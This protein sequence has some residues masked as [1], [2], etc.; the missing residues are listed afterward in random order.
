M[1]RYRPSHWPC[2]LLIA[3]GWVSL[4]GCISTTPVP[5]PTPQ[6]SPSLDV[7]VLYPTAAATL[8]M[9]QTL[10][11]IIQVAE[12][13]GTPVG[14]AR[15]SLSLL[16]PQGRVMQEADLESGP[17]TVY[18]SRALEIP[19]RSL[20]GLL[21]MEVTAQRGASVG[22]ARTI[23]NVRNSASEYLLG[24]YGFWLDAP[25]LRSIVP[26]LVAERGDAENGMVRWGGS[27]PGQHVFPENWIEVHWRRGEFPLVGQRDVRRFMLEELGELGLT[28]IRDLGPFVQTHFKEWDA[29][30]VEARGQYRQIDLE[31][32]VFYAPQAGRTYAIG[33]TVVE[34]P[35]GIDAHAVLRESFAILNPHAAGTAPQPLL[36][37]RPAPELISPAMGTSFAGSDAP[38][39][40]QWQV[41]SPLAEDDY[42]DVRLDWNDREANPFATLTTREQRLMLPADLVNRPNCG[43]FNWRVR[44]M[45]QTEMS[46]QGLP[47]GEALSYF[48]LYRYLLWQAAPGPSQSSTSSCPNAQY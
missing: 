45:R 33:T 38:I 11:A 28:P 36:R 12:D 19:H 39:V 26:Q 14:D 46:P 17:G 44:L 10:T 43:V 9:G 18:R 7:A 2:I 21:Q 22:S 1:G 32:I 13:N 5:T 16:D 31:W 3:A 4:A 24:A 27:L 35:V 37:L 29:W 23:L 47:S 34:P 41:N 6:A 40:L 42:F 25:S 48:S 30:K 20:A 8:E 15:V